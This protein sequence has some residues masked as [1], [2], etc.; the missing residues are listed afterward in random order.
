NGESFAY[1]YQVDD[2]SPD[3]ETDVLV[4]IYED[5]A[6]S[7]PAAIDVGLNFQLQDARIA[8]NGAGYLVAW[9]QATSESFRDRRTFGSLYE[10]GTWS[11]PVT[12]S[13]GVADSTQSPFIASNGVGY[14]VTWDDFR[15]DEVQVNVYDGSAWSGAR[16]L[17][18]PRGRQARPRVVSDGTGYMV[19]WRYRGPTDQYENLYVSLST[20]GAVDDF[21]ESTRVTEDVERRMFPIRVVG[22]AAGYAV[23]WNTNV[24]STSS[25]LDAVA[26]VWDGS[27]FS[28]PL[29]IESVE[30][31]AF[32][33]GL[34]ANDSG[35]AVLLESRDSIEAPNP[36]TL[37][38]TVY[39]N[40]AWQE[41]VALEDSDQPLGDDPF[42]RSR[43][44]TAS[45]DSYAISW[46][47]RGNDDRFHIRFSRF[48]GTSWNTRQIEEQAANA[49]AVQIGANADGTFTVMW[50]QADP[51]GSPL[52]RLPW[53]Y[54]GL[55]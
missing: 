36:R 4:R 2:P 50:R 11:M 41:N 12:L 25:P 22:G 1:V 17:L 30:A 39:A 48:D 23:A 32:V 46:S 33:S 21:S 35:F 28:D 5:G 3:D 31:D 51:N 44:I 29:P 34:A 42:L 27:T 47:E 55:E 37:S 26:L 40:G 45:D 16:T 49:D 15:S 18:A 14:A 53:A 52:V 19:T 6:W 13:D 8:S 7:E 20:T 43:D 38:A 10:D 24:P 9:T 54:H